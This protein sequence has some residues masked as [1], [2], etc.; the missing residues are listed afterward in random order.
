MNSLEKQIEE[1]RQD[2]FNDPDNASWKEKGIGPV[3]QASPEARVVLIGQAPGRKVQDTGIP[4]NDQSGRTG[5]H[6]A[7][8]LLLSRQGE[9]R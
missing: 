1:I 6:P 4:F 3:F 2:I 9:I 7:D 8:R 5:R